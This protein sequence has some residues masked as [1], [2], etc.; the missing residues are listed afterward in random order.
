MIVSSIASYMKRYFCLTPFIRTELEGFGDTG[1]PSCQQDC[2]NR[3]C[4]VSDD[5][6]VADKFGRGASRRRYYMYICTV[7][8]AK[9]HW[10]W[11]PRVCPLDGMCAYVALE[12][13]AKATARFPPPNTWKELF[14]HQSRY[15]RSR[16]RKA[17]LL[18]KKFTCCPF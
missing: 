12:A 2:D 15:R 13:T 6:F 11:R 16:K 4:C 1:L 8:P 17:F 9:P 18:P 7:T 10:T 5:L 14:C 3:I